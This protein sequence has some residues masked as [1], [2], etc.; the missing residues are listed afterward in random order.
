M[1]QPEILNKIEQ[2]YNHACT[3][4][5]N[6]VQDMEIGK[7]AD[8]TAGRLARKRKILEYQNKWGELSLSA[9]LTCE[10][11]EFFDAIANARLQ[12]AIEE[13]YDIIA[14]VLRAIERINRL[15]MAKHH[16]R[17]TTKLIPEEVAVAKM[18]TTTPRRNCDVYTMAEQSKRHEEYCKSHS[19]NG[20]CVK[21]PLWQMRLL[22]INCAIAWANLLYEKEGE[23]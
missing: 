7:C 1:I 12:E 18:E 6:F 15:E 2:H 5:P 16:F 20:R 3:K 21:C 9:V 4:H 22:G 14:V 19:T 17:D 8:I 11:W 10:M 13:G 23:K